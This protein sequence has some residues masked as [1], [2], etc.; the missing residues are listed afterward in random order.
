[1]ITIQNYRAN[2]PNQ[3]DCL[4]LINLTSLFLFN[5]IFTEVTEE[6][7]EEETH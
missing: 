3:K 2:N 1:M 6:G 7:V 4:Y 5:F